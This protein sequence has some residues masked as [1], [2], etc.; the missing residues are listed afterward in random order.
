M[1]LA[2]PAFVLLF[3]ACTSTSTPTVT[4]LPPVLTSAPEPAP[5][6]PT[7]PATTVPP[8]GRC[9]PDGPAPEDFVAA[10]VVGTAGGPGGDARLIA[11][12]RLDSPRA[13]PGDE[14]A[15]ERIAVELATADGAPATAAGIVEVELLTRPAVLRMRFSSAIA[16]TAVADVLLEGGLV[17]RAFVVRDDA[18]LTVD[19]HLGA[20]VAAA[21]APA[22]GRVVVDLRRLGDLPVGT[23]VAGSSGALLEPA[24]AVASYPLLVAGYGRSDTGEIEVSVSGTD[25]G[26]VVEFVAVPAYPW[27]RFEV[28]VVAGPTGTVEVA[29]GD[30]VQAVLVG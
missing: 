20:A 2:V 22:R 27:G 23:A 3:A 14:A 7:L 6:S 5:G 9:F 18:G 30:A 29:A 15:C 4:S 19:A 17:R 16:D 13:D 25:G 10:G 11:E 26:V 24:G 12:I 1:R 21:V 28:V 8:T